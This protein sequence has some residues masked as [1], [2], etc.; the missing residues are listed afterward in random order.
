MQLNATCLF[1]QIGVLLACCD[2]FLDAVALLCKKRP[3]F[4]QLALKVV[5]AAVCD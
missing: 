4:S 2:A 3:I 1:Q 5:A